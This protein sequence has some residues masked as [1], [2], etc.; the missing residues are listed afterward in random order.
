[1]S[2]MEPR[3]PTTGLLPCLGSTLDPRPGPPSASPEQFGFALQGIQNFDLL[4]H[5]SNF[6]LQVFPGDV[7]LLAEMSKGPRQFP[8]GTEVAAMHR[9]IW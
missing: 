3:V 2:N 8:G 4:I 9:A 6:L 7:H 1:M 5:G